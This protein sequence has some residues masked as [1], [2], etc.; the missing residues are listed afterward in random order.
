MI[1]GIVCVVQDLQLGVGAESC[2]SQLCL[3]WVFPWV[4]PS[5]GEA[6]KPLESARSGCELSLSV[7]SITQHKVTPQPG[8]FREKQFSVS[9]NSPTRPLRAG[10]EMTV[11]SVKT[12]FRK[13]NRT[14]LLAKKLSQICSPAFFYH[15]PPPGSRSWLFESQERI[16]KYFPSLRE[17]SQHSSEPEHGSRPLL[18]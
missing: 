3:G 4:Q 9:S 1:L 13:C 17:E 11:F 6:G 7:P 16:L 5:Q 18:R 12:S 15:N 10:L 14:L 8:K 2:C